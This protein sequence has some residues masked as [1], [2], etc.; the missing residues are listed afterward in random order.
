MSRRKGV[1]RKGVSQK[2]RELRRLLGGRR[3]VVR[4]MK[5][6]SSSSLKRWEG[7][8]CSPIKA[9]AQLVDETHKAVMNK[10]YRLALRI[11]KEMYRRSMKRRW[12]RR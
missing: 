9:H 6:A 3:A 4:T 11:G 10:A 1:S 2:V 7:R 5:A 8:E 12:K